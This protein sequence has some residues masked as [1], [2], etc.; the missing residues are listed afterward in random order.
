M[1]TA[2]YFRYCI[3]HNLLFLSSGL[4]PGYP[5]HGPVPFPGRI[6]AVVAVVIFVAVVIVVAVIVD[7]A[8]FIVAIAAVNATSAELRLDAETFLTTRYGRTISMGIVL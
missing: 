5:I 1:F 6:V 3:A 2:T 4:L 8:V 7:V